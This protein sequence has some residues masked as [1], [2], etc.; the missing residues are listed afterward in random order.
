MTDRPV[1]QVH[2]TVSRS[3]LFT[4]LCFITKRFIYLSHACI[5]NK[6][7]KVAATCTMPLYTQPKQYKVA[8]TCTMPLY[9]QPKQYKVAATCTMPLYTQSKQYKVAATC[10][11]PLYTQSKLQ[12]SANT[13]EAFRGS[14]Q[15]HTEHVTTV[16]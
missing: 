7:Y 1:Y 13:S 2:R 16:P 11:M 4:G 12:F 14:S 6:Q 15:T 8:A 5:I 10:T 9:T 3:R